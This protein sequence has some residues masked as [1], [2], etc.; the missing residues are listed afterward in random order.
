LFSFPR[1]FPHA[2]SY[3]EPLYTRRPPPFIALPTHVPLTTSAAKEKKPAQTTSGGEYDECLARG[4]I[5]KGNTICKNKSCQ[6]PDGYVLHHDG[7]IPPDELDSN[8]VGSEAA[9]AQE[10]LV[11]SGGKRNVRTKSRH[12]GNRTTNSDQNNMLF[13]H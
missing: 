6:C 5:C 1:E 4:L 13:S 8:T 12:Q 11:N 3:E 2:G 7:C 9:Q 10:S